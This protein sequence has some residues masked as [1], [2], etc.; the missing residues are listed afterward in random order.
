MSST[1]DPLAYS[2]MPIA[3]SGATSLGYDGTVEGELVSKVITHNLGYTPAVLAF[4][5]VDANIFL[6]SN[7][8]TISMLPLPFHKQVNSTGLKTKYNAWYLVSSTTITFYRLQGVLVDGVGDNAIIFKYY[9]FAL[10][11]A[12]R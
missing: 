5:Q 6:N 4:H 7:D 3:K 8:P 10:P 2:Y 1:G 12:S 11:G 9:L